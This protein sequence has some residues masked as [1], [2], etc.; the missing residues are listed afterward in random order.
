MKH[1]HSTS[2]SARASKIAVAALLLTALA[3]APALAEDKK[4]AAAPAAAAE[5]KGRI[6]V[7]DLAALINNSSAGKSIRSQIEKQRDSYR[8]QIEKQEADLR[9][10]EKALVAEQAKASKE[11]FAKKRKAFQ[12]KVVAAQRGV[13][14]RRAAFDKA[15]ASALEKLR[16]HVVKIVAD[17]AGKKGIAL[18][19]DRQQVVL[20][21][22]DMDMT[23]EVMTA[24]NA[25]VSSIP[26]SIK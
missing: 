12:D 4:A 16:E 3:A 21:E 14:Q 6:A 5:N 24:L 9:N 1:A 8:G 18:V 7:V 11:D 26:V 17:Q 2:I 19:L 20:V 22:A 10:A 15:Y 23:K 25:K 13:Q